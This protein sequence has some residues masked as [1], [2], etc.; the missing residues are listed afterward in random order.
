MINMQAELPLEQRQAMGPAALAGLK[1]IAMAGEQ[2]ATAKAMAVITGVRDHLMQITVDIEQLEPLEPEQVARRVLAVNNDPQ[3]RERIL[4]GMTLVALFDGEPCEAQLQLLQRAATAFGVAND[5]VNSYRQV[6]ERQLLPIRL[7][8]ARRGFIRQ[9]AG[10]SLRQEGARAA[11]AIARVL[12]GQ[13]DKQMADHYKTLR[14]YPEGSFGRAYAHFIDRNNFPF[15]GEVGG[16]PPPV[17]RHDC[18]HVLG[19]YGTTAQEEGAVLGFQAGFERLDPFYVLMF[20]LAEF[21]LGIGASPTIPG[22][23]D[24]LDVERIFAGIA[25]G[26]LVNANLIADVD[27]WDHFNEPL[28]AVRERFNVQ[29]RGRE[30]IYPASPSEANA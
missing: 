6:M 16:P 21:E 24:Q 7:D 9:A 5:P 19:G 23:S 22:E 18:C 2:G 15:P 26:R 27:P 10:A 3:W 4:R 17:M 25:H 30:A 14:S 29:P 20:A 12:L 28:D 11:L 8:I 13:T 1:T